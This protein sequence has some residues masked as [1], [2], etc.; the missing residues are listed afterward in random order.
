LGLLEP[1]ILYILLFASGLAFPGTYPEVITLSIPRELTRIFAYTL[2]SLGL[3][4]YLIHRHTTQAAASC[5]NRGILRPR[6][7]DLRAGI[8]ALSGLVGVGLGIAGVS[9]YSPVHPS[10]RL[11]APQS[12]LEWLV[13]LVSCM[14]T[15]YL[16]ES[17]FR[18]YLLLR[19]ERVGIGWRKATALSAL[20]FALCHLYEGPWGI[21]QAALAGVFLSWVLL[22][23]GSFH[24]IAWAHGAYNALVY[25][26]ASVNR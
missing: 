3:I 16:E 25:L 23:R 14:G 6:I 18:G 10:P 15:G 11:E 9:L 24:G 12:P 13:I 8:I 2:P 1:L 22:R 20:L 4:G 26:S 19:L 17:Y 5:Q 21:V 7:G